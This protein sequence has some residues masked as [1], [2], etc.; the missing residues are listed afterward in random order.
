[1]FLYMNGC[2]ID[3]CVFVLTTFD[4][5]GSCWI[6]IEFVWYYI[7]EYLFGFDRNVEHLQIVNIVCTLPYL[8]LNDLNFRYLK[9]MEF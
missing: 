4:E 8:E 1:M 6:V 2:F 7:E 5:M 3:E 9:R